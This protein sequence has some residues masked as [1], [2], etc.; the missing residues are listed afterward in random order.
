MWKP[1]CVQADQDFAKCTLLRRDRQM[2]MNSSHQHSLTFVVMW[3]M[4]MLMILIFFF[5]SFIFLLI[6]DVAFIFFP[7]GLRD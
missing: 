7:A 2:V 4:L 1:V 3:L 6:E 5:L